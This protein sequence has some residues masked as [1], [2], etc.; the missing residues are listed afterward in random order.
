MD[1]LNTADAATLAQVQSAARE[2]LSQAAADPAPAP[3]VTPAAPAPAPVAPI[4]AAPTSPAPTPAPVV[5]A[6]AA[7]TPAPGTP[8]EPELAEPEP[9]VEEPATFEPSP[10][11]HA[12]LM[13]SAEKVL[14][15]SIEGDREASAWIQ[16][17]ASNKAR[18]EELGPD[19]AKGG[20]G[21]IAKAEREIIKAE[22]QLENDVIQND[23]YAK[24]GIVQRIRDLKSDI[25]E[26]RGERF[27]KTR[28]N[29]DLATK[30]ETRYGKY[31]EQVLGRVRAVE[32]EKASEARIN[33]DAVKFKAQWDGS[34]PRIGAAK[35]IPEKSMGR[36]ER[37]ARLAIN[38]HLNDVGPVRNLD[39]FLAKQADEYLQDVDAHHRDK[40]AE[41]ARQATARAGQPAPPA[42]AAPP[43]AAEPSNAPQTLDDVYKRTRLRLAEARRG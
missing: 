39:T 17:W 19:L 32:G 2:R 23:E 3:E 7:P 15:E 21:E 13:A 37:V 30:Y 20:Q 10:E 18:V 11:E 27:E 12:Q 42:G 9:T 31:R 34:V 33:T 36:F 22:G 24:S 14:K 41:Y 4:V 5:A 6:P 35:G 43:A 8:A 16:D 29:Q 28:D 38:V 1:P 25:R 26:L 40:S